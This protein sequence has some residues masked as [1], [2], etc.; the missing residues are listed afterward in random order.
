M[1]LLIFYRLT[2]LLL[3]AALLLQIPTSYAESSKQ[4]KV[5][6]IIP[7]SGNQPC[8]SRAKKGVWS[9]FVST[10]KVVPADLRRA[11]G[12]YTRLPQSDGFADLAAPPD[13]E[14][15]DSHPDVIGVSE[16]LEEGFVTEEEDC[17]PT[18]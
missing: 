9:Q 15:P 13:V 10:P 16:L 3:A 11:M 2:A 4:E 12:I 17:H 14:F 18:L 6:A 7:L 1:K 8:M 5:A